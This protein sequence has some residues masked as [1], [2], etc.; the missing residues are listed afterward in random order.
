MLLAGELKR[1]SPKRCQAWL[2][3]PKNIR[4][5]CDYWKVIGFLDVPERLINKGTTIGKNRLDIVDEILAGV[6]Q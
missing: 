6:L 4:L 2:S 3:E 5:L 1:L